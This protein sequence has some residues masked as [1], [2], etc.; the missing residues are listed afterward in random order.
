MTRFVGCLMFPY[1]IRLANNKLLLH[2]VPFEIEIGHHK[3]LKLHTKFMF[4]CWHFKACLYT[5]LF[6]RRPEEGYY[7]SHWSPWENYQPLLTSTMS[8]PH[9]ESC[10]TLD[11]LTKPQDRETI[12]YRFSSLF[13]AF[14]HKISVHLNQTILAQNLSLLQTLHSV[15]AIMC[16]PVCTWCR[17][18]P[19]SPP[20]SCCVHKPFCSCPNPCPEWDGVDLSLAPIWWPSSPILTRQ[21][22]LIKEELIHTRPTS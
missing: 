22:P 17:W 1:W 15:F 20:H 13:S 2:W 12:D 10:E 6:K 7:I 18:P 8:H 5:F 21:E 19:L 14:R 16:I 3:P 9:A 4:N 11:C